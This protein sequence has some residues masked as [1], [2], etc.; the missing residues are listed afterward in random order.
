MA[1][2]KD[3]QEEKPQKKGSVV[4]L[5]GVV[6]VMSAVAVGLGY[7]IATVIKQA[8]MAGPAVTAMQKP[9]GGEDKEGEEKAAKAGGFDDTAKA[10]A[11]LEPIIVTLPDNDNTWVRLEMAILLDG[12]AEAPSDY[13]KVQIANDVSGFL[14]TMQLDKVFYPSGYLHLKEDLLDRVRLSAGDSARDVMI[15]SLVAE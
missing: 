7:G 11:V 14:R 4:V 15:L 12:D 6:V 5:A 13:D 1:E 2:E 3:E 10:V 9:D 8:Q